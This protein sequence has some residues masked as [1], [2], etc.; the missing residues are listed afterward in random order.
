[1]ILGL[2]LAAGLAAYTQ[3]PNGVKLPDP[4]ATPGATLAMTAAQV[5]KP[6]YSKSVRNVPEAVKRQVYAHYGVKPK[7]GVCC[8]VD[9][10]ISLELGGSNDAANLWPQP[11]APVPAAHEK[12]RV[13]NWL[14]LQVCA[15]TMRLED[16]QQQIR[17][18]WYRVY[19]RLP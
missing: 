13:E 9:H 11:W 8:E 5:C 17:T 10:L 1:M 15:G 16:A 7:P 6:G 4:D 18:N 14:H 19:Q 12:D 2:V 3:L